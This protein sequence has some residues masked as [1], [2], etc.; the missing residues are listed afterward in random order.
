MFWCRVVGVE[1]LGCQVRVCRAGEHFQRIYGAGR[2]APSRP[3]HRRVPLALATPPPPFP[4]LLLPGII[5]SLG[6]SVL[7]SGS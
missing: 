5:T 6:H 7:T 2:A 1:V 3:G 4:Y